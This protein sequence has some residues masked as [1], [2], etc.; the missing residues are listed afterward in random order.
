MADDETT[1]DPEDGDPD[2]AGKASLGGKITEKLGWLTADRQ[3]EAEGR[4]KQTDAAGLSSDDDDGGAARAADEAELE[5][6]RDYDELHPDAE[7]D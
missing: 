3:M 7:P 6:R 5:V 1:E 2:G 4:L